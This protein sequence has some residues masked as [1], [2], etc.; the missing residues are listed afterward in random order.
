MHNTSIYQRPPAPQVALKALTKPLKMM[1]NRALRQ[2]TGS[3][4]VRFSKQPFPLLD[5]GYSDLHDDIKQKIALV[6]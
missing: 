3:I 5:F 4:F 2:L 1:K 6:L